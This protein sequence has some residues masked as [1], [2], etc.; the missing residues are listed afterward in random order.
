M[1]ILATF[2]DLAQALGSIGGPVLPLLL[3]VLVPLGAL[4]AIGAAQVRRHRQDAASRAQAPATAA[5][6]A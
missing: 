1:P 3:L 5:R 4:A 6:S 2:Q